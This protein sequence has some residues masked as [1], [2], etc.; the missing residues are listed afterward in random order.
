MFLKG[1]KKRELAWIILI[2]AE[3][4]MIEYKLIF[5]LLPKE[6]VLQ[7]MGYGIFDRVYKRKPFQTEE[8]R[9]QTFRNFEHVSVSCI[10]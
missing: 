10:K 7:C 2:Q 1:L 3:S 8:L 6:A 5:Y 4:K 9:G